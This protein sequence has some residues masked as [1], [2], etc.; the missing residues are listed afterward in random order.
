MACNKAFLHAGSLVGWSDS[1][2]RG[3]W[4]LVLR[5]A[6]L[7]SGQMRLFAG[8]GIVAGSDPCVEHDETAAKFATMLRA[9][10]GL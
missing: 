5:C 1:L 10:E 9:L 8:A 2:G 6:E 7:Q 3:R 4:S